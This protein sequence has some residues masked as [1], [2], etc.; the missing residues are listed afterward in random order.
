[1]SRASGSASAS[2]HAVR[3]QAESE[4]RATESKARR[5]MTIF[6]LNFKAMNNENLIPFNKRNRAELVEISRRAGIASGEARRNKRTMRERLEYLLNTTAPGEEADNGDQI[7]VK[8]INDARA[9]N[10]IAIKLIGD[11]CGMFQEAKQAAKDESGDTMSRREAEAI[12]EAWKRSEVERVKHNIETFDN[13]GEKL[14]EPP[15]TKVLA[16]AFEL[17]G[18]SQNYYSPEIISEAMRAAGM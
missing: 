3:I 4:P 11:F 15:Q 8:L 5:K 13:G 10:Y 16:T 6:A 2:R 17:L 12:V 1:M 18:R 7:A 14:P 9:G